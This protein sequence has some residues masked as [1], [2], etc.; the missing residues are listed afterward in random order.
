MEKGNNVKKALYMLLAVLFLLSIGDGIAN[1]L[2]GSAWPA[3]SADIGAPISYQSI[4]IPVY[5]AGTILGSL[6]AEKLMGV[7]SN[8]FPALGRAILLLAAVL[9]FSF[10]GSF[11]SMIALIVL[12]GYGIALGQVLLD[13]YMAR[14]YNAAAMSWLQASFGLG[15]MIAPLFL[16]YTIGVYGS[17]RMGYQVAA[18]AAAL[19]AIVTLVSMPLWRVHAPILPA[20]FAAGRKARENSPAALDGGRQRVTAKPIAELFRLPGTRL[21]LVNMVFFTSLEVS[22]FFWCTSF[23]VEAKAFTAA[24][25]ASYMM[26]FYGAQVVGR[27]LSGAIAMRLQDSKIIRASQMLLLACLLCFLFTPA[28]ALPLMLVLIGL[29]TGPIF[30]NLIHEVPS[31][32]GKEYSQGVIGLQN[33]AANVGNAIIP[34]GIGLV[35][36]RV[37]FGVFPYFLLALLVCSIIFK[38][39]LDA[40]RKRYPAVE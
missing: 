25:A 22:I 17:W 8:F 12:I 18:G 34:M 6:T 24:A 13:G 40:R 36:G 2:L 9:L 30:P 32:V 10:S 28:S 38:F 29:F 21:I 27:I 33:A 14:H 39:A 19:I 31:I 35:C 26:Y 5:Y 15:G 37:G 11:A 20:R 16:A 3:I 23:L 4:M 1:A 7:F